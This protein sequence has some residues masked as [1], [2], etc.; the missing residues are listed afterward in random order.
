MVHGQVLNRPFLHDGVRYV[1]TINHRTG[2]PLLRLVDHL[3]VQL[4]NG[5]DCWRD[6]NDANTTLNPVVIGA[7]VAGGGTAVNLNIRDQNAQFGTDEL[8]EI[9]FAS[10]PSLAAGADNSCSGVETRT[11][12]AFGTFWAL[13]SQFKWVNRGCTQND[14]QSRDIDACY[15]FRGQQ[16]GVCFAGAANEQFVFNIVPN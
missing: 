3:G 8:Y 15:Q 2:K 7:H 11:S 6:K 13:T 10:H 12:T 9:F 1:W 4:C 16:L 14:P 5:S